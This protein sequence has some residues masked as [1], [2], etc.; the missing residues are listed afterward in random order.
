MKNSNQSTVQNT[1]DI[2][3]PKKGDTFRC[4]SCGMTISITTECKC[5][6]PENVHFQCCGQDLQKA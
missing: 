5:Q 1:H 6:H 4:S 2:S 3:T